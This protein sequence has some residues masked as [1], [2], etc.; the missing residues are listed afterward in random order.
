MNPCFISAHLSAIRHAFGFLSLLQLF[1]H[2]SQRVLFNSHSVLCA[3]AV[4]LYLLVF[5]Y[6]AVHL[7][8]L[9]HHTNPYEFMSRKMMNAPFVTWI[10][11]TLWLLHGYQE[12]VLQLYYQQCRFAIELNIF[13]INNWAV[14]M[15]QANYCL[16]GASYES[17]FFQVIQTIQMETSSHWVIWCHCVHHSECG[18]KKEKENHFWEGAKQRLHEYSLDVPVP[19]TANDSITWTLTPDQMG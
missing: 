19:I 3:F 1:R 11:Y 18:Q 7:T 17:L 16:Q 12:T 5:S 9:G 14:I 13:I 2:C 6:N 15:F 4:S 8:S 10:D